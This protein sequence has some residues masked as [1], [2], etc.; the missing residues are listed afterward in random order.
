LKTKKKRCQDIERKIPNGRIQEGIDLCKKNIA[1]YLSDAKIIA[2]EG[3][4]NHALI[5][6]EFAVE[7]LGKILL[8]KEYLRSGINPAE[9]NGKNFCNHVWKA[10]KA[11]NEVLDRKYQVIFNFWYSTKWYEAVWYEATTEISD[12]A[13]LDCAFVDFINN[14]WTCGKP[15]DLDLFQAFLTHFEDKMKTVN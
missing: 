14:N 11:W 12:V 5:S 6:A 10:N 13:R 4:L 9:I 15:I 7:E 2:N 1:D 3:R 8:L